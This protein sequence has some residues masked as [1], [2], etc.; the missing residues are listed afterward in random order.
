[1]M[2]RKELEGNRVQ[3]QGTTQHLSA[4]TE[5]QIKEPQLRQSLTRTRF[6]QDLF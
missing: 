3:F 2:K 1:M 4:E 5:K 6:E